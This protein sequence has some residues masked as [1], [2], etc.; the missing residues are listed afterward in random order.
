MSPGS[1]FF[2]EP[3]SCLNAMAMLVLCLNVLPKPLTFQAGQ[4]IGGGLLVGAGA[5]DRNFRLV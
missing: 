2:V 4:L 1:A 3:L 5:L